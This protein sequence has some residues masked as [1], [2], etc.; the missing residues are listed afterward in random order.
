MLIHITNIKNYNDFYLNNMSFL[1]FHVIKIFIYI[2]KYKKL[3]KNIFNYYRINY[4]M[5]N[6]FMKKYR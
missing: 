2:H 1:Y 5:N 6:F 4:N 3:K